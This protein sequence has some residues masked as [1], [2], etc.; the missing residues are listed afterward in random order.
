[1]PE[2]LARYGVK[3]G[4]WQYALKIDYRVLMRTGWDL[5]VRV[6][7]G[8]RLHTIGYKNELAVKQVEGLGEGRI[9]VPL[10]PG[11]LCVEIQK[12]AIEGFRETGEE[13]ASLLGPE[14]IEKLT[15]DLGSEPSPADLAVAARKKAK[16]S[17]PNMRRLL[18]EI[19][20][21]DGI[22]TRVRAN[23]QPYKLLGLSFG[24]ALTQALI[25]PV[26][27][28]PQ[29]ERKLLTGR[30]LIYFHSKPRPATLSALLR[31]T[32]D[33]QAAIK[34]HQQEIAALLSGPQ[35][36]VFRFLCD[37]EWPDAELAK[38][39]S[40]RNEVQSLVSTI[41]RQKESVKHAEA[42]LRALVGSVVKEKKAS[43]PSAQ[44]ALFPVAV[45]GESADRRREPLPAANPNGKG[46]SNHVRPS[47]PLSAAAVSYTNV[48]EGA[49]AQ[50]GHVTAASSPAPEVSHQPAD[51]G[52]QA[53]IS[54][55]PEQHRAS[56][57]APPI[58]TA[59]VYTVLEV[60]RRIGA[61]DDQAAERIVRDSRAKCPQATIAQICTAMETKLAIAVKMTNPTAY[62]IKY[63]PLLFEPASFEQWQR[64]RD[65]VS[66]IPKPQL[67]HW[68]R[69][70]PEPS[71]EAKE[72]G[73]QVA[74]LA[75]REKAIRQ[76]LHDAGTSSMH[77]ERA[78]GK[79]RR[80]ESDR[81]TLEARLR[82]LEAP[83][84]VATAGAA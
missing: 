62:L 19:E 63:V 82:D 60:M 48:Q 20:E 45:D 33:G 61:G 83:P 67:E 75:L 15:L 42:A 70:D 68:A 51:Q 8:L 36:L 17:G 76:E 69:S 73:A 53:G 66:Q 39:L 77:I 32:D 16:P 81:A 43:M 25:T 50:S 28:L 12:A 46:D 44:Q 47:T 65:L 6:W 13:I 5:R 74:A 80:L 40:L 4:D 11:M 71:P 27:Q 34:S 52:R 24:E 59:E 57:P 14:D 72:I 22:I 18:A 41:E 37:E 9:I 26:N 38:E 23:C 58:S 30:C 7:A 64:D 21:H 79:Q 54:A 10:T 35:Q 49:G 1:V 55:S 29:K 31:R 78:R 56:L 2:F 3:P 84:R